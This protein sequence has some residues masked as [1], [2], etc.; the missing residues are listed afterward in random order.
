VVVDEQRFPIHFM[1]Q[2]HSHLTAHRQRTPVPH[3]S[4]TVDGS[5]LQ[6]CH[7]Q[8]HPEGV[9]REV[10]LQRRP[11]I[12]VSLVGAYILLQHALFGQNI[13]ED[14]RKGLGQS[15]RLRPR[16]RGEGLPRAEQQ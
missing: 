6:S 13:F 10:G 16:G 8:L 12:E 7:L 2:V 4:G 15:P 9:G 5:P 1:H 11:E 14:R 3:E